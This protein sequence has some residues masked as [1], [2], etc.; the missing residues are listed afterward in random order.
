METI[1]NL[2]SAPFV[3]KLKFIGVENVPPAGRFLKKAPQKLLQRVKW[4]LL[5]HQAN[6]GEK[7]IFVR[8]SGSF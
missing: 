5:L 4:V 2:D 1:S 7:T 6:D 3:Y 8:M